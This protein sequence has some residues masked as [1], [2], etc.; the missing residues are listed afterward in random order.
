MARAFPILVL[1][2]FVTACAAEVERA[3]QSVET[4]PEPVEIESPAEPDTES[5][6]DVADRYDSIFDDIDAERAARED[7]R[8]RE[9]E[10]R[11]AQREAE[12]RQR[13]EDR[14]REAEEAKRAEERDAALD[15]ARQDEEAER[16]AA[17][18]AELLTDAG[19]QEL[20]A[21]IEDSRAAALSS[22]AA[23]HAWMQSEVD[24][25]FAYGSQNPVL[26][27]ANGARF[28]RS[29]ADNLDPNGKNR[30]AMRY[31]WMQ[32]STDGFTS[33]RESWRM[34][35]SSTSNYLRMGTLQ[36]ELRRVPLHPYGALAD[37]PRFRG[38]NVNLDNPNAGGTSA[39]SFFPNSRL[40][41]WRP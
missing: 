41:F 14:R 24:A 12:R 7:S 23:V 38:G 28:V 8:K 39:P 11:D 16:M 27:L 29:I 36:T 10:A 21:K 17:R 22:L 20:M 3:E 33:L 34:S 5:L 18:E 35:W 37:V 31:V 15:R 32:P 30:D 19:V 4:E 6:E 1:F 2:S 26:E 9:R 25:L 13:E 40:P